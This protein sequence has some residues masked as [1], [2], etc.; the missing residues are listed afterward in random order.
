MGRYLIRRALFLILVLWIVSMVTFV[1][2][3][4]LPAGDVALRVAGAGAHRTTPEQIAAIRHNL[5][6]DKPWYVQ[7]ARFAKG[8]VPWP[9]WFLNK[10]VYYS[11]GS[12]VPVKEELFSRL[13]VTIVLAI[14]GAI[15]WV[16]VGIPIG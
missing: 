12:F 8:L 6:L 7:Y 3:Y 15:L 11:Y 5:G 10:Q 9:G 14:G 4:K 1:I 2:F 16:M 13:P